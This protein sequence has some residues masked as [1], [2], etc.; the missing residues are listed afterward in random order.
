MPL[1]VYP[2][3]AECTPSA[4]IPGDHWG[5]S[6]W[7]WRVH[8]EYHRNRGTPCIDFP[9]ERDGLRPRQD[10]GASRL[11]WRCP[12]ALIAQACDRYQKDRAARVPGRVG[13]TPETKL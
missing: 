2:G 7:P 8:L 9:R 1:L 10:E 13:N 4:R 3:G 11:G 12:P 6:G 5:G